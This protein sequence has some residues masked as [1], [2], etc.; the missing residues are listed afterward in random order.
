MD[1]FKGNVTF[2]GD[3]PAGADAYSL[4]LIPAASHASRLPAPNAGFGAGG[5]L[6]SQNRFYPLTA[7]QRNVGSQKPIKSFNA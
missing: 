6:G 5:Y 1:V 3:L 7:A 2:P 4:L